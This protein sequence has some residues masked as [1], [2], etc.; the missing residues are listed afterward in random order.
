MEGTTQMGTIPNRARAHP[1]PA[2][3]RTHTLKKNSLIK[4]LAAGIGVVGIESLALAAD[5]TAAS[6][7]KAIDLV[8]MLLCAFL[9]FFMQA[10]FALVETGFT[11]AKNAINMMMK[12]VMDFAVGSIAFWAIGFGLMFGADKAGFIGTSG[13]FLADLDPSTTEGLWKYGYWLFQV[14]FAATAATIASGAMAERTRFV[15]YLIYSVVISALIYPVVGHWIWGG[16]WLAARGMVDFAGSTVVH[17]VGGWAGLVGALVL[18]PRIGKYKM[19]GGKKISQPMPGHNIPVAALGAFILWFGWF[20]FNPGSTVAGTNLAIGAIA[21]TTN[22]A[23]AAGATS[24]M[25]ASWVGGRKPDIGMTLNGGLAGLVAIT[26]PCALVSPA[27]AVAIGALAGILVVVSIEVL[28]KVF[29]IDDPVSAISVHAVCGTFGTLSV[30]LFAESAFASAAGLGDINGL[31]FGGGFDLLAVQALGAVSVFG[32]V[33]ATSGMLFL[34]IHRTIGLR[35][36]AAEESLGLDLGEH[37]ATAYPGFQILPDA[38][39]GASV[40]AS[41]SPDKPVRSPS[42]TGGSTPTLAGS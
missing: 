23:A 17:S 30:G 22:L 28:D 1:T 16:G 4:S 40:V 14:V 3:R 21:V 31:F 41:G 32:W 27:S 24:G 5:H 9:V 19:V 29:H 18:G 13:F 15:G 39:G 25:L 10:G 42:L 38:D 12:N 6:N 35:V 37:G 36:N 26:A 11:R 8:W 33:V 20:G 7:A 34:A 2:P